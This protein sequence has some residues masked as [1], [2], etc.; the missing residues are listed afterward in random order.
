MAV[1]LKVPAVGESISEVQIGQW[2]KGE[3][4][5]VTK[6]EN[7]VEI[8]GVTREEMDRFGVRS[9][10]LACE[11]QDNGFF[12]REITP[13]TLPDGCSNLRI[14]IAGSIAA[15]STCPPK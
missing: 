7:V 14:K 15:G 9:Q 11:H 10:N 3:G 8:E 2:L 5:A 1:E 4:Q 12:E 6:D 13:L